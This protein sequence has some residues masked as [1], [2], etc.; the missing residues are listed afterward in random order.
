MALYNDLIL[1]LS[2]FISPIQLNAILLARIDVLV[3]FNTLAQENNYVRP[4]VNDGLA[5]NIVAGRHPVIEKQLAPGIEYIPNDVS[6]SYN[7]V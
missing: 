3:S 4:V 5:L 2:E 1:A 7:F 6:L